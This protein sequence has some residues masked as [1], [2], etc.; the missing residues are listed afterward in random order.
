M[1]K[2]WHYVKPF[3]SNTGTSRTDIRTDRFAISI[4]R[5]CSVLT[6]YKNL[7]R[8]ITVKAHCSV[9]HIKQQN[10]LTSCPPF[11]PGCNIWLLLHPQPIRGLPNCIRR[12]YGGGSSSEYCHNYFYPLCT[13][14][15]TSRDPAFVT[16]SIK[17]N[18]RR[19]NRLMRKGHTEKANALAV[20][21]S[22]S[23]T[24]QNKKRFRHVLIAN[25]VLSH[26]GLQSAS[27]PDL[28]VSLDLSTVSLLTP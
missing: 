1:K 20:L 2:L 5:V 23:I 13:I 8:F 24:A 7:R 14:T 19:K 12:H 21:I 28:N 11:G 26:C 22:K 27:S 4:P 18:L 15:V 10:R 16:P 3:S 6:R 9:T 17:A 25:L